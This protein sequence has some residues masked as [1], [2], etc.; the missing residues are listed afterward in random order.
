M[1]SNVI[2]AAPPPHGPLIL[3]VSND[4]PHPACATKQ[5]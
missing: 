1:I 3:A 4:L 2:R 5:I